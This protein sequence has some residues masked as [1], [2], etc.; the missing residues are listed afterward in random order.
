MQ[1]CTTLSDAGAIVQ[2][3]LLG[4]IVALGQPWLGGV[5]MCTLRLPHPCP[6]SP[7]APVVWWLQPKATVCLAARLAQ[8]L[9]GVSPPAFPPLLPS[10]TYPCLPACLQPF[11][12]LM[13][14]LL[15]QN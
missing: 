8:T 15:K 9:S 5:G 2:G 6:D 7:P 3:G 11:V 14:V 1:G 4:A 13:L 12:T 10:S